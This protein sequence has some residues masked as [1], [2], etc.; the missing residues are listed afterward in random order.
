MSHGLYQNNNPTNNDLITITDLPKEILLFIFK[1]VIKNDIGSNLYNISLACRIF[2]YCIKGETIWVEACKQLW[3]SK[4]QIIIIKNK[5]QHMGNTTTT[6]LKLYDGNIYYSSWNEMFH[7]RAHPRFDGF[8]KNKRNKSM[9]YGNKLPMY[10]DEIIR[11]M[12]FYSPTYN[13]GDHYIGLMRY[14]TKTMYPKSV[15]PIQVADSSQNNEIKNYT[16][17][18]MSGYYV[19]PKEGNIIV[20]ALLRNKK[21][22]EKIENC[23]EKSLLTSIL[24]SFITVKEQEN[25]AMINF[26]CMSKF[27]HFQIM[28]DE[29]GYPNNKLI[30]QKQDNLYKN[31]KNKLCQRIKEGSLFDPFHFSRHINPILS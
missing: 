27:I 25:L 31:Y 15:Q 14:I 18:M 17:D 24:Q 3:D 2:Y 12:Q 5:K 8:Y 11:C 28:P 22:N 19:S 29:Y 1:L 23:N 26:D 20:V 30:Y 9:T 10:A 13:N 7:K 16:F 6:D 21:L 4:K